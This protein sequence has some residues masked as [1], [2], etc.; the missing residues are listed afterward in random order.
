M[1]LAVALEN[2]VASIKNAVPSH[3]FDAIGQSIADLQAQG[4]AQGATTVGASPH[5]PTLPALNGEAV[6]LA[7]LSAK[8]T[9]VLI[10]YRGGWCPYC[11]VALNA[12]AKQEPQF[13]AANAKIVAVT[14]ELDANAQ[15]TET[16]NNIAFPI[17]LDRGNAFARE[18]GLVFSLPENLQPLYREIGIDLAAHNGEPSHELPIPATYVIDRAG[19]IVWSFVE[20]DFTKRA[21]PDAV[22]AA[23][24]AARR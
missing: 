3:I 20:A 9:L 4:L 10:F 16:N 18:L 11:N 23:V 15:A 7:A 24:E 13:A 14:P 8:H 5:L 22:L 12:F 6:D 2:T 1:S 19:K 21:E 17:L